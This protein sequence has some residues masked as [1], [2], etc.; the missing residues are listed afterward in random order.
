MAENNKSRG[1]DLELKNTTPIIERE[2]IKVIGI[3]TIL[4]PN[5]SA[6]RPILGPTIAPHKV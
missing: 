5:R 6:N 3:K 4:V 1:T 2:L